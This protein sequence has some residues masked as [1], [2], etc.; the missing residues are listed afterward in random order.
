MKEARVIYDKDFV[1][2]EVDRRM[3]GSFVEHLGR[4]VYGGI[5]EPEHETA[6]A[7]GFRGDVK[8]LIRE[9][10]VTGIRYPG[11]NF[12]SGYNWK[13]GVGPKE[14][15]PVRQDMAWN[16]RETNEVGTNEFAALLKELDIQMLMSVN[17]GTGTPKEAGELVEYCNLP[18]GTYWSDK[19]REHGVE[20]PHGFKLWCLGNEMDGAWQI[21]CRDDRL[22]ELH[23]R[24][25]T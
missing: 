22:R 3:F 15:R 25:G 2:G 10:G 21:D 5:Y 11:G 18:G 16:V 14:E 23:E 6:D 17:L 12:V 13:D 24:G 19:R 8:E 9:L 20:Q 4:C 1:I 7:N